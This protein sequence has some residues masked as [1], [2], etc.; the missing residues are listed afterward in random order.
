VA[1]SR[2]GGSQ[3]PAGHFAMRIGLLDETWRVYDLLPITMRR[4][5]EMGSRFKRQ[6]N[7]S[8]DKYLDQTWTDLLPNRDLCFPSI[9][10]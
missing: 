8:S 3:L 2:I 10:R 9:R 6:K 7:C 4:Y 1:N 5:Q